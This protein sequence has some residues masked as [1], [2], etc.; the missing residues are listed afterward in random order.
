MA[1][2]SRVLANNYP[3]AEATRTRVLEAVREL[4][5]VVNIHAKALSGT[6]SRPIAFVL[7]DIT[8]PSFAQVA[9]GV[10]REAALNGRLCLVCTT[11]GDQDRELAVVNLMRE[12]H[13]GAVILIGG[14]EAGTANRARMAEFARSLSGVGSR[15]V[16]CGRPPMGDRLPVSVVEYDNR[17]GAF[18]VTSHLLAA[19]HRRIL[20]LG[21]VRG[22]TA[23]E[24]RRAGFHD[25]LRSYGVAP[26]DELDRP[27][28]LSRASGYRGTREA[29][30][31]GL[32]FTAVFAGTDIVATGVLAA[33][34]EA[35]RDVPGDVSVVGFDDVPFAADLSP[36]LTTV[37]VPYEDMG[38]SA[39]RLALEY[40]QGG[41]DD[42]VVLSTQLMIRDSVRSL[43]V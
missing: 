29:L 13:A 10:E 37:R 2:V 39:V 6:V 38:R 28:D 12:Q 42:H 41:G 3:V 40:E 25:A 16:L 35:G 14:T 18:N 32:G 5:Y 11:H 7:D 17:G 19:G 30:R 4:D 1:T 24:Q 36:A 33:L 43:P 8:T 27:S 23:T 20:F 15:L 34:R 31:T 26:A 21:G 9:A 22:R